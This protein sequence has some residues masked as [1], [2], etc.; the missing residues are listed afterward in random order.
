MESSLRKR[1][2][3][4]PEASSAATE[5]ECQRPKGAKASPRQAG[6]VCRVSCPSYAPGPVPLSG[7][8]SRAGPRATE[9]PPAGSGAAL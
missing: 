8:S 2:E 1:S 4:Q 9:K 3:G 7:H 5:A 6:L